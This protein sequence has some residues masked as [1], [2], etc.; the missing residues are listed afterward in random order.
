MDHLDLVVVMDIKPVICAAFGRFTDPKPGIP[1]HSELIYFSIP[2]S[3]YRGC[4][5]A[6]S[7]SHA[8]ALPDALRL[9]ERSLCAFVCSRAA[10]PGCIPLFSLFSLFFFFPCPLV[11]SVNEYID[12]YG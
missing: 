10:R 2:N 11:Y 9:P 6:H 5:H 3:L 7:T 8:R 4:T 12:S 1:R